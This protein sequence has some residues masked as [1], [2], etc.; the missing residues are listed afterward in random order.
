MSVD[1]NATVL[2]RV[3]VSPALLILRVAP[4]GWELPNFEA[5]QFAV[6]GLPSRAPRCDLAASEEETP[7]NTEKLIKRAY[8]I[9]SSSISK[10][11]VEFYISLVPSGSLTPRLFALEP[12]DSVWLGRKMAG[13]FTLDEV[14]ADKQLVLVGTGTGLA[15]YMSMLRTHSL[16]GERRIAVLHGARHS[17]E[18]GYR[19]ELAMLSH[20]C[21]TFTYVPAISRPEE[22][23][24]PWAGETGHIQDVWQ[25]RPLIA[26]WGNQPTADDSHLFLCGNPGMIEHMLTI[27]TTEGFVEHTKKSPGQIHLE[28]FW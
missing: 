12:G 8:S 17:W 18:L 19:S 3:E 4:V 2:E 25:R 10:E 1:F 24:V 26:H 9:A 13:L 16:C 14:P 23:N 22:E 11:Y 27:L 5:G 7:S 20:R 6:L 28:R 15:P 21:P